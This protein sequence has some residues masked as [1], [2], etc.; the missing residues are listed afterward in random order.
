MIVHDVD[1]NTSDWFALRAGKP[2]ASCFSKLITSTGGAS[3]SMLVYAEQLG[4]ELFAGKPLDAWEGNI[5]TERGHEVEPEAVLA[6]EMMQDVDTQQV[7]FIT[8]DLAQYGCSPDRE[9]GK[10]GLL[11]IKC[12][13][14]LHIE[15]LRYINKNGRIPTKF[16]AQVQG[17]L[18]ITGKEWADLFFYHADLPTKIVR[19][20]PDQ[21]IV[22]GLKAQ[23]LSCI[24]ERNLVFNELK[25]M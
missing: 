5:Y 3:K 10:P 17:Q 4:G 21:K 6:Y 2:T 25:E 7:G 22:D 13:P 9:V 8:D 12:L 24:A 14:K 15:A 11:E 18:F 19:V 20:Y 23:L 1:Q 16:V